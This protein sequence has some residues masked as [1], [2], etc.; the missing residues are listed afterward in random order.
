MTRIILER[1]LLFVVPFAL[2][3]IYLLLVRMRP[4]AG[5]ARTTPWT[6]LFIAGLSLFSLSFVIW[7]LNEGEPTTGHYVAPHV[8]NGKIVPGYVQ[9][10]GTSP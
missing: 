1:M 8:A 7:G 9:P 6:M 4:S 3:G 10:G 2:Y 5:Q